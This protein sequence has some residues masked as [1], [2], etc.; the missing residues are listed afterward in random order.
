MESVDF[1]YLHSGLWSF[2]YV[3]W[4][5]P[6]FNFLTVTRKYREDDWQIMDNDNPWY[7]PPCCKLFYILD[8]LAIHST[9]RT[10]QCE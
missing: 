7:L 8:I 9:S 3:L 4:N 6:F 5:L 10:C 2:L 1:L